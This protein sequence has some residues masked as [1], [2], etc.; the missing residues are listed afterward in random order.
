MTV[1]DDLKEIRIKMH[2]SIDVVKH[3]FGTVRTGKASTSLVEGITVDYYGTPTKIKE[4]AGLST[5]EPQL[6]VIQPWDPQVLPAIEKAIKQS[7]L[8]IN[9]MNDGKIIRL[10]IP[11]LSEERRKDLQKVV[12]TM[13]E[14]GRIAIRN[15]RRVA[16]D[17]VKKAE[18][19][20]E[21]S[22]DDRYLYEEDIQ[23]DTDKYIKEVDDLL[24]HKE[25]EILEI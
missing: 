11:E 6:V 16:I 12:K 24:H 14:N 21:I 9:P 1:E 8:G 4:L 7:N 17:K 5:P 19:N 18:K 15:E 10:P 13:A 3:E 25:K 22:E 20:K 2:K 23:K